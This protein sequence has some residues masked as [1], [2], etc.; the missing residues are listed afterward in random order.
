MKLR[1]DARVVFSQDVEGQNIRNIGLRTPW[2]DGVLTCAFVYV[3]GCGCVTA[4]TFHGY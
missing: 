1:C 3:R 4:R 2:R